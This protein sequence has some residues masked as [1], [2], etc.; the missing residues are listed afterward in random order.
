MKSDSS[1]RETKAFS[2]F[3]LEWLKKT[4][5]GRNKHARTLILAQALLF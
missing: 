2:A 4:K 3:V 1:G 5:Q